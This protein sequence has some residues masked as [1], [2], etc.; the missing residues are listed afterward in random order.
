M[1]DMPKIRPFLAVDTMGHFIHRKVFSSVST[2][3]D[4]KKW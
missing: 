3:I 2:S 1:A 4:L